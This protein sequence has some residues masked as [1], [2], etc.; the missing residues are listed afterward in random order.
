MRIYSQPVAEGFFLISSRSKQKHEL[1]LLSQIVIL[2]LGGRTIMYRYK[3]TEIYG[4]TGRLG[5]SKNG[6]ASFPEELDLS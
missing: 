1:K 5:I 6:S 3:N 2:M 4:Q